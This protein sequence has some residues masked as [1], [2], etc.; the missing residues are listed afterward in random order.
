MRIE[1]PEMNQQDLR[2]FQLVQLEIALAV[3]KICDSNNINYFLLAGSALGAVRHGGFIP[4]DDDIDIGMLRADYDQFLSCAALELPKNLT[5]QNWLED[6]NLSLPFTKI[7]R[8][9]S[10][11]E[12]GSAVDVAG[13]KGIFIDIFPLDNTPENRLK[14]KLHSSLIWILKRVVLVKSKQKINNDSPLKRLVNSG[15]RLIWAHNTNDVKYRRM[16]NKIMLYF[17]RRNTAFATSVGGSYSYNKETVRKSWILPLKPIQFEGHSF[18]VPG[19]VD[20][21]L[22]NLYGD[23]M[24]LPPVELQVLRHNVVR[25]QLPAD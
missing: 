21:Y 22:H 7:R 9:N 19:N 10:V 4:W 18:N 20:A 3:K 17:A 23:F 8:D 6:P 25:A 16:L 5:V 2:D 13:H 15:F 11:F 1:I 12:E 14:R 24:V